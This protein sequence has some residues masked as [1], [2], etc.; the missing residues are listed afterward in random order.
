MRAGELRNQVTLQQQTKTRNAIGGEVIT[1]ATV[2]TVWADKL[3]QTSREFFA[4]QKINAE[5]TDLFKIR[6]REKVDAKMRL[7]FRGRIYDIIGADD[8]DGR[9]RE[10]W[11]MCKAVE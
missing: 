11:L 1:W 6:Y 2:A 5:I 7:I 3:H 4:A 9:R 8:P 10:L